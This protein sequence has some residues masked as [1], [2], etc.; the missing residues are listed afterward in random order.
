VLGWESDIQSGI[1]GSV[2]ESPIIQN[3]GTP[4][5]GLLPGNNVTVSRKL[6]YWTTSRIRL[7]VTVLDPRL[8]VYGTFGVSGGSFTDSA[9][10]NFRPVGTT[11]YATSISELR[12]GLV[13]GGGAEWAVT[14]MVSLKGEYLYMDF[15]ASSN[16]A[17]PTPA[18]PPF[19]VLYNFRNTMQVVRGGINLKLNVLGL[20]M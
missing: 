6:D 12:Y 8:M 1:S 4:F 11:I 15:Y 7:G 3:N 16:F 2:V 17:Y 20:G 10:T 13:A 19:S 9:S 18:L 14:D 5:P